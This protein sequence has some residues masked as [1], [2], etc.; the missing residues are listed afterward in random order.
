[1]KKEKKKKREKKESNPP[2][3]STKAV[4]PPRFPE[5]PGPSPMDALEAA[6]GYVGGK[7]KLR[8]LWLLRDGA[9]WR[10]RDIKQEIAS[11]TDMMLSQS[12]K[13]L[14]AD[15]LI[16][17]HAFQEIPPRVEYVMTARGGRGFARGTAACLVG[18]AVFRCQK[19]AEI[20]GQIFLK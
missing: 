4:K 12:L 2:A 7:W 8:I 5:N 19:Y 13:E 3:A 9:P 10:Y 6:M 18:R 20:I 17:R 15:G 11:I 1:M 14:C 16:E